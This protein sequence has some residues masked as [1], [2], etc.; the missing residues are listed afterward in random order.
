MRKLIFPFTLI[1]CLQTVTAIAQ[2]DDISY[3]NRII[4]PNDI[5]VGADRTEFYLLSL[6]NK[7]VAI[8]TNLTGTIGRTHLVDSLLSLDI[9]ITKVFSPEHGFRG[10]SEA[11]AEVNS[12]ID[13]KT[14]I[15]II[16]L[17]GSHKKPTA[18]DF[19]DVDIVVFDIQ[20]VGARFY[21]YISS[22]HYLMEACA[23]NQKDLIVLD[24]PNPNGFYVDGPMLDSNYKSF[25]GMDSIPVVHGLTVG[26]FALMLNGENWLKNGEKCKLTVISVKNY[27]H[28]M[29]YQLPIA[30]SPNLPNM[31]SIYLYP[32]LCLFE[33]T[34]ISIGRG[35]EK[36][37]QIY[38]HPDLKNFDTS[39]IPV[40]IAGKSANPKH[41]NK[42]CKGF[43]VTNFGLNV[44]PNYSKLYL[45]WLIDSYDQLGKPNDFFTGFFNK[46]AGTDKLKQQIIDGRT[47]DEIRALWQDQLTKYKQLRKKYLLYP[48]FE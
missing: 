16:S 3:S 44:L 47:E 19:S 43:D 25:V 42:I 23:E 39:F 11:G 7:K 41:E 46:L 37:F 38:G 40:S 26:E 27:S 32:S 1:I 34:P 33:G 31:A 4:F 29:L 35:T 2:V 13:L 8:M 12:N 15:S 6:E 5:K 22:L 18:E 30:P 24:R 21:T 28:K 45:F 10:E 17:Y 36:A 14:G 9:N 20:D 48:D